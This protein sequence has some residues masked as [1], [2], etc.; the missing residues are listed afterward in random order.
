VYEVE[1]ELVASNTPSGYEWTVGEGPPSVPPITS[2]GVAS[3]ETSRQ[4]IASE[5]FG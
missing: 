5:M 4:S 2:I 1:I 3:I